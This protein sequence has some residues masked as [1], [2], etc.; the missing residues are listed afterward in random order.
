MVGS[1]MLTFVVEYFDILFDILYL[2]EVTG[3]EFQAYFH[4]GQRLYKWM[5]AFLFMGIL[6]CGI[7]LILWKINFDDWTSLDETTFKN[8]LIHSTSTFIFEE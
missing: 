2:N 1:L 4:S 7:S 5:A 8:R 3:S 6:K